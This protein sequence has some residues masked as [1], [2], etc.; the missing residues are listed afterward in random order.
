MQNADHSSAL[1]KNNKNAQHITNIDNLI[2]FKNKLFIPTDELRL[3]IMK[4]RHD[5]LAAGHFGINKTF[6]LIQ[7]DFWWPNM[8]RFVTDYVKSCDCARNK[9]IR[10]KPFGLLQPL[11]I[12]NRPWSS[13][14]TDFIVELPPS[15]GYNAISVWVCRLTKMAH[16]IPC[17]TSTTADQLADIF[18]NNIFRLHGLP[19]DI[20]SDRG[21]Q[22]ISRF[23]STFCKTLKIRTNLST[24]FHPQT[25]G[26]SERVNQVLEQYLRNF[27]NY[28]QDNWTDLLPLAEFSYNNTIH[29][30]TNTSPFHATYGFHPHFDNLQLTHQIATPSSSSERI[31]LIQANLEELRKQLAAAQ[32]TYASFANEKR[33][34]HEYNVGDQVW[35]L[36][37]N[38][39]T[40]RPSKKLDHKRLGP[41]KIVERIGKLAYRLDLPS[42]MKIHNVFHISLLEPSH[43]NPFPERDVPPPDPVNIDGEVEYEV[44]SIL[45]SRLHHRKLQYLVHWKGYK[46][47]E[48]TWEPAEFLENSPDAVETFHT[49]Y[50]DKPRL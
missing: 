21:P 22:F 13:I 10:H 19:N 29:T 24:A 41:F 5:N 43:A 38:I 46:T 31:E 14:S 39:R 25:D 30:S 47:T 42:T 23:W 28:N 37:T 3:E 27:L 6:D 17:N 26:Q 20:V 44:E 16:F 11:P 36:A 8:H 49:R 33:K 34:H 12:P 45:D 18:L 35:L 7:R 50:P 40:N 2:Y 9:A 4:H 1:L 48:A 32:D 15:N